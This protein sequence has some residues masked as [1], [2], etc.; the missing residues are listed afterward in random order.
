MFAYHNLYID[1]TVKTFEAKVYARAVV[2][3]KW[4]VLYVL[5]LTLPCNKTY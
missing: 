2:R 4:Q 3:W 5:Y 1:R